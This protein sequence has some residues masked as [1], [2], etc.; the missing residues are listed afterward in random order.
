MWTHTQPRKW[1]SNCIEDERKVFKN[2]TEEVSHKIQTPQKKQATRL[3]SGD[4]N[5]SNNNTPLQLVRI[6]QAVLVVMSSGWN[7]C[8]MGSIRRGHLTAL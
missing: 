6:N 5:I 7:F 1:L 4:Y 8:Y 3:E 2:T